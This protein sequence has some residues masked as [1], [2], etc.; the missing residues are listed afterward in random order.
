MLKK[1]LFVLSV[2]FVT[3]LI[4]TSGC[5]NDRTLTPET[6]IERQDEFLN[7]TISVKGIAGTLWMICTEEGC[8]PDRPCCNSCFGSLA[9]YQNADSFIESPDEGP[10]AYQSN[11]PALGLEFPN[12][13]GCGGNEC[14]VTCEPLQLGERYTI[15][16]LLHTCTDNIPWCVLIVESYEHE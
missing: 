14:E 16:G 1:K 10:Y 12:G 11:E 15:T 3:I 7:K 6:V 5:I 2:L 9:L 4:T 8:D 13:K